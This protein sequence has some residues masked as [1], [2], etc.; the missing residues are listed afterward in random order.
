[1]L[2]ASKQDYKIVKKVF[3]DFLIQ[4]N[5]RK[6]VERFAILEE[7]YNHDEHFNVDQLYI[8]MKSKNYSVS[9][10]TI[11]NTIEI[12]EQ[13]ELI[14]KHQFGE[15]FSLYEKSFFSK[16]HDHI[17]LESGELIEFCDPRIHSIKS[18]LEK[19]FNISINKYS[20]YFY[21]KYNR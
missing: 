13:A 19:I 4:N 20:L 1:M 11:Y 2:K 7:I 9:R 14:R 3:E 16:Q 21:G 18:D 15:N 6:T 12:L 17:M 5:Q 10:A 8:K